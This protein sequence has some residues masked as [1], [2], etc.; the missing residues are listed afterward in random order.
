MVKIIEWGEPSEN[1]EE[2]RVWQINLDLRKSS[3]YEYPVSVFIKGTE[4]ELTMFCHQRGGLRLYDRH[5]CSDKEI[6]A[7]RTLG[8]NI[9]DAHK[10]ATEDYESGDYIIR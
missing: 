9:Y 4:D 6:E 10:F 1:T 7:I 8:M 5:P 3:D 2:E